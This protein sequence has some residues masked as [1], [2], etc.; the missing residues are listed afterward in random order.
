[1]NSQTYYL[2]NS[3]SRWVELPRPEVQVV[4]PD[5]HEE[6]RSVIEYEAF[7]NFASLQILVKG[8]KIRRLKQSDGKIHLELSDIQKYIQTKCDCGQPVS[9]EEPSSYKVFCPECHKCLYAG[10]K[11]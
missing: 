2:N 8:R 1:M 11:T 7:G 3:G 6:P 9:W 4:F 10:V 5:G